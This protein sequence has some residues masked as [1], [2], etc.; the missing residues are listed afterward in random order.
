MKLNTH[1]HVKIL[2]LAQ[3]IHRPIPYCVGT[4]QIL[5]ETAGQ[6][7]PQG[8]IGKYSDEWIEAAVYWNGKKG[9]LVEALFVTGWLD[10]DA[11]EVM[12]V[13]DWSTHCEK[14]IKE[15]LERQ[16]LPFLSILDDAGK[17]RTQ[18]ERDKY[19]ILTPACRAV[20]CRAKPSRA[21]PRLTRA[22]EDSSPSS[23]TP[24]TAAPLPPL[25]SS[26]AAPSDD[27]GR[28]SDASLSAS[29]RANALSLSPEDQALAEAK[30]QQ[31]RNA[32]TP[33]DGEHKETPHT[34][35]ELAAAK[36]MLQ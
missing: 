18:Q 28:S 16:G 17:L 36:A 4:L 6:V 24:Q 27:S 29:T 7:A 21:K 2:R 15:K 23:N 19:L 20:P 30:R 25:G 5:W 8:D 26:I 9:A 10:L 31:A 33:L 22:R 34:V 35:R 11:R 12:V 14:Y 3:V 1:R 32:R 13:H